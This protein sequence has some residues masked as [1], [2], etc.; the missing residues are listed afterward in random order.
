MILLLSL[1][2]DFQA[3][4]DLREGGPS[5]GLLVPAFNHERVD[6]SGACLG[7]WEQLPIS[8]H[9]DDFLVAIAVVGLIYGISLSV[10]ADT[11]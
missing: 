9:V 2:P 8:N 10:S 1:I 3:M 7:A 6:C 5:N 4:T 11:F